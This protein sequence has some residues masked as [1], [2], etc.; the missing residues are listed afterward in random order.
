MVII[1]CKNTLIKTLLTTYFTQIFHYKNVFK[2][3]LHF[4]HVNKNL[5]EA[6]WNQLKINA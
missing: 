4:K 1:K 5:I 3:H 2:T 6:I